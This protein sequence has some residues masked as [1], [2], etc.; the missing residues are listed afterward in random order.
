M[1]GSKRALSV[2][3]CQ[4]LESQKWDFSIYP[5]APDGR[6]PAYA[7]E[8]LKEVLEIYAKTPKGRYSI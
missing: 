2:E 1:A 6:N 8:I 4:G 7:K 3:K 5:E